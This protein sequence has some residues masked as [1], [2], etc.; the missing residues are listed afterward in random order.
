MR[1]LVLSLESGLV[2]IH[3]TA[4]NPLSRLKTRDRIK[5]L[6]NLGW[7]ILYI[8][9]TQGHFLSEAAADDAIAFLEATKSD[10]SPIGQYRALMGSGQLVTRGRA[11]LT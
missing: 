11:N 3:V 2:E 7:S 8:W 6:T 4:T 10:P 1:S 5:Y 9:V